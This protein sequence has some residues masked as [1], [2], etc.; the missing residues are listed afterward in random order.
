M[1]TILL[2][3]VAFTAYAQVS[4]PVPAPTAPASSLPGVILGGGESWTRGSAYRYST[5]FTVALHVGSGNWYSWSDISTPVVTSHVSSPV[6]SSISTGGA[7]VASQSAGGRLSLIAI[8]QLGFSTVQ[9]TS[10]TAPSLSGSLGLAV[11]P[12]KSS[13]FWI[14][15]Y[16]KAQNPNAATN[17]M[18]FQPGIQLLYSLGGGK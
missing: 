12:R 17:A 15:F 9:A 16:A 5:D 8:M 3:L 10:T 11:R 13:N 6:V 14:L 7:W 2:A 18:V 1:R 4:I